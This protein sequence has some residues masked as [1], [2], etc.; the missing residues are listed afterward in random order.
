[1]LS[2]SIGQTRWR[3]KGKQLPF[4]LIICFALSGFKLEK[5]AFQLTQTEA[6]KAPAPGEKKKVPEAPASP[7]FKMDSFDGFLTSG[8]IQKAAS[9]GNK[10]RHK[11][12]KR[13]KNINS[14]EGIEAGLKDSGK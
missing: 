14:R 12:S 13:K 3:P 2:E 7:T 5:D 6:V 4:L 8:P 10:T 1:M 11:K 9:S